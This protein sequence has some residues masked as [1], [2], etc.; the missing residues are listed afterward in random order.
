MENKNYLCIDLKCFFASVE[1]VKRNLDPFK[2][3][4]VVAN[5]TRGN[6]AICLA[7]SPSLKKLGVANRC[8]IFEIPKNISY[9]IAMPKMKD[10]INMSANIYSIYLKYISKND[11]LVYSIDECFLD[12]TSYLKFYHKTVYELALDIINDIYMQTGIYATAG[13][14]PNMFLAKVALDILAKHS[15]SNIGILDEYLFKEKIWHH[16]PI[17]DIWN[18]GKGIAK[19][20]EKYNVYDLYGITTLNKEILYKE[21]GIN[22]TNLISHANGIE[23][24]TIKQ[25]HEYQAKNHSISNSQILFEDYNFQEALLVV[26]E[27]VEISTLELVSK[28][29]ITNKIFLSIGYSKN[30]IKPSNGTI[31]LINYTNSYSTISQQF[32]LLYQKIANRN[33]NIRKIT[34]GFNNVIEDKYATYNLFSNIEMEEKE[35]RMQETILQIKDKYGKNSILKVMN[36]LPK[37]TTRKRN[38]LIGGHNSE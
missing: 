8:R 29:L 5:P 24:C 6:G 20:L 4:L 31:S 15:K 2:T 27:M 38:T 10:Y 22:A 13:I 32:I 19:R 14:G 34:I 23:T 11:I 18:I 9:I 7:I 21:F 36:L 12:V 30:I 26:K 37:A 35:K 33:V 1:C 3:N 17:T 25:C 16:T 28:H